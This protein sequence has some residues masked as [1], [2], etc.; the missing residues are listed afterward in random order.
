MWGPAATPPE[1]VAKLADALRV[2]LDT[3]DFQAQAKAASYAVEWGSAETYNEIMR[4]NRI[5]FERTIRDA[6]IP[7]Q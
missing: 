4:K 3:P 1:I 2:A 6:N 7:K 5:I